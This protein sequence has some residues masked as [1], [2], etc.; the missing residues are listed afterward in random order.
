VVVLACLFPAGSPIELARRRV[1]AP[2][3]IG[4]C[5]GAHSPL[6]PGQRPLLHTPG[7]PCGWSPPQCP[8]VPRRHFTSLARP[9]L[10]NLT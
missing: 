6:D 3:R 4:S 2:S 10:Q 1:H 7:C 5:R 8:V 9:P